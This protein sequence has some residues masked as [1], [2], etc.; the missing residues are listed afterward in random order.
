[1]SHGGEFNSD[2][3]FDGDS[4]P[5]DNPT[6]VDLVQIG[7]TQVDRLMDDVD[8]RSTFDFVV[9]RQGVMVM[10]NVLIM[11]DAEGNPTQDVASVGRLQTIN[12]G[13]PE[14]FLASA[15]PH[16]SDG[17][18]FPEFSV[19]WRRDAH[20]FIGPEEPWAGMSSH[21]RNFAVGQTIIPLLIHSE[22]FNTRNSLDLLLEDDTKNP[23]N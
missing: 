21:E 7:T 16:K 6:V 17:I 3:P 23:G 22:P 5:F 2:S 14:L 11:R 13:D 1:M 15:M 18:I 4:D 20:N 19:M 8:P 12:S 9:P 10:V